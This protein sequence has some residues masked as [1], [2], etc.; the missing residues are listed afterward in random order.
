MPY[1]RIYELDDVGHIIDGAGVDCAGD[2]IAIALA[3]TQYSRN[4]KFEVWQGT[5][6]VAAFPGKP[7]SSA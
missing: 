7:D 2:A 6:L 5:R 1:Y 3:S 4:M